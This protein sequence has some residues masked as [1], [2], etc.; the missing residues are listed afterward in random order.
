V[1]R[2]QGVWFRESTRRR[3]DALGVAGWA[4]NR[5]DGS[6]EVWAEGRPDA[7]EAL[8]DYCR[9]GPPGASVR[10]LHVDEVAPAGIGRFEVR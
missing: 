3:A 7:V 8:L 5:A 1:G 6:L 4:C 10:D 9:T 2:V